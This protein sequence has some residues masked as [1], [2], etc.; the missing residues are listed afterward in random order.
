MKKAE[1]VRNI[2]VEVR[3]AGG[4]AAQ[5]RGRAVAEL[6]LSPAYARNCVA[7][8]WLRVTVPAQQP[9][10]EKPARLLSM[11]R[12]A[13]RKREARAQARAARAAAAAAAAVE[14]A[15]AA[16]VETADTV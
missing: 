12:D 6:G 5:A 14:T 2:I 15:V 8:N 7:F 10:A 16:A 11:S 9:A 4:D 1:L 3:V 13:I